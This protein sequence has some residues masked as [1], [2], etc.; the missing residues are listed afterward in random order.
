MKLRHRRNSG[1]VA[2]CGARDVDFGTA[3]SSVTCPECAA[4]HADPVWRAA[5]IARTKRQAAA[6]RKYMRGLGAP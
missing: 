5:A 3:T 6:R 1:D 2:L 4:K